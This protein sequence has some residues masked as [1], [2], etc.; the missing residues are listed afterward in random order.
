MKPVLLSDE[1]PVAVRKRKML[2]QIMFF[3]PF[4]KKE[5]LFDKNLI[6]CSSSFHVKK[7][8]KNVFGDKAPLYNVGFPRLDGL[9]NFSNDN[10]LY[11][12]V[13]NFK[14]NGYR[15]GIYM[16]TYRRKGEFDIISFMLKSKHEIEEKL[17]KSKAILYVKVHY[18]FFK[19]KKAIQS[20]TII[21]IEENL[22]NNDIYEVLNSFDFL[23][24]DY[25]SIVFDFLILIKPI[26]LWFQT[27]KI[28]F[29]LTVNLY[30][31]I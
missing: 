16:P 8:L 1:K 7:L 22:I 14:K 30:M 20:E 5:L 4:L 17:L 24:S 28:I 9:F 6:V 15:V 19:V 12:E 26:Y 25:S 13:S 29:F 2:S 27:E 23:I 3:F 18:D 31:T 10:L 11:K 21:I